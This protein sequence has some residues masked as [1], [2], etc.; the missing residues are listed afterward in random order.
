MCFISN[1]KQQYKVQ[2]E[3]NAI[4]KKES[5]SLIFM[6]HVG[7]HINHMDIHM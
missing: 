2:L 3:N 5:L 1:V 6:I 7:T 4:P